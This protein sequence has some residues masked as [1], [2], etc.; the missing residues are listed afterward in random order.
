TTGIEVARKLRNSS[1]VQAPMVAMSASSAMLRTAGASNLFHD[2][3][4]KPF[5]FDELLGCISRHAS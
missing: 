5:D 1:N 4:A 2:T 3:L